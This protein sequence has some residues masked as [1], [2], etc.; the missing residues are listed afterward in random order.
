[1]EEPAPR[2]FWPRE[3][4]GKYVTQLEDFKHPANRRKAV[5]CLNHM[6]CGLCVCLCVWP[7]GTSGRPIMCVLTTWCGCGVLGG[8]CGGGEPRRHGVSITWWV[9]PGILIVARID[10][11]TESLS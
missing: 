8:Y 2:M 6:V 3:I 10:Q 7:G 11:V 5:E 9:H 4:W 1:M